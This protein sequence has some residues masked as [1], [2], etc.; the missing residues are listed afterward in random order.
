MGQQNMVVNLNRLADVDDCKRARWTCL[1]QWYNNGFRGS[2]DDL[3][4]DDNNR[5]PPRSV[6][7]RSVSG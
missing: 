5:V 3:S 6:N 2:D 7:F 4:S 1:L